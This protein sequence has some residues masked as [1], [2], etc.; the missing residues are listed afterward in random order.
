MAH[1]F[2]FWFSFGAAARSS[3]AALV[4]GWLAL[5]AASCS[6]G[7]TFDDGGNP[8]SG[9]GST[10]TSTGQTD[11]PPTVSDDSM[12]QVNDPSGTDV[13]SDVGDDGN[14]S[15]TGGPN[16]PGS[17]TDD[18]SAGTEDPPEPG[19]PGEGSSDDP[20]P[21][22]TDVGDT[23]PGTSQAP[24]AGTADGVVDDTDVG[25]VDA[26]GAGE[27]GGTDPFMDPGQVETGCDAA[28]VG[29]ACA[30]VYEGEVCGGSCTDRCSF[31]WITT[32]S[33]GVWQSF[34]VFPEPCFEC[35]PVQCSSIA[36]YCLFD[37]LGSEDDP[38]TYQCV[39]TPQSCLD[40][41]AC[42][43]QPES[44]SETLCEVPASGAMMSSGG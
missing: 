35:G 1:A 32:C 10:G 36:E 29:E 14:S 25:G 34:E 33:G 23:D 21:N 37:P 43:C 5:V 15:A 22:G 6:G 26:G 30:A 11:A 38:E 3:R 17:V 41:A 8:L 40:D 7:Q 24:D 19:Q 42:A 44:V 27:D 9:E 4:L 18:V 2:H 16:D 28:V 39:E 31:C 12:G 13:T 20:A